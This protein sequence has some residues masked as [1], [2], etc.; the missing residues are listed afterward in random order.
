MGLAFV[1][2]VPRIV[3]LDPV[4]MTL[5]EQGPWLLQVRSSEVPKKKKTGV[6]PGP[7]YLEAAEPGTPLERPVTTTPTAAVNV[8]TRSKASFPIVGIGASAGGLAAFEAFFSGMPTDS[9][10]AWPSSWCST[11][12]RP[13]EHPCRSGQ[14]VHPHAGL[15]GRG[16]HDG[17]A[18]LRL[19]IPPNRDMALL[20]GPCSCWNRPRRAVNDCHRLFLSLPGPGPARAGGLHRPFGHGQ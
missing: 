6:R 18:Q 8:G 15:R 13:Q 16:R 7:H 2:V 5:W 11:W 9:I 20:N 3:K 1:K 19:I 4:A 14:A 10:P 17:P 12:P